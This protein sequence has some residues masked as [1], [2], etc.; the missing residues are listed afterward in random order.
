VPFY[1]LRYVFPL[2]LLCG[3]IFGA[4]VNATW[5]FQ[6]SSGNNKVICNCERVKDATTANSE[7]LRQ[8]MINLPF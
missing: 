5:S 4:Y 6:A 8:A 7:G 2:T 1:D 3:L